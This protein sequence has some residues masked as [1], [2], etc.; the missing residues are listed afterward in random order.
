MIDEYINMADTP[1]HFWSARYICP[2]MESF[3]GPKVGMVRSMAISVRGYDGA[4]SPDENTNPPTIDDTV[5]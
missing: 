1:L 2:P 4:E 5:G 3:E